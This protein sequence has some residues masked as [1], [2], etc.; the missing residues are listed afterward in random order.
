MIPPPAAGGSAFLTKHA[1]QEPCG[2]GGTDD[3]G[4]IGAHGMHQQ[5][6]G[7][8]VLLT[9]HIGNTGGHTRERIRQIE[10]KAIRKLRHPSRAKKIKDFYC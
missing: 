4:H 5:E 6:V 1:Q 3:A 10:N 9:F 7:G 2:D 8:I